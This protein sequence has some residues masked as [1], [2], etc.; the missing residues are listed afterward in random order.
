MT[1]FHATAAQ[2]DPHPSCRK[3]WPTG[4]DY[5]CPRPVADRSG[6]ARFAAGRW[7]PDRSRR[8]RPCS[9]E[10]T[11]LCEMACVRWPAVG[12]FSLLAVGSGSSREEPLCQ[13]AKIGDQW[14]FA[15]TRRRVRKPA[16]VSNPFPPLTRPRAHRLAHTRHRVPRGGRPLFATTPGPNPRPVLGGTTAGG[17]VAFLS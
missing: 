13:A 6:G 3:A 14:R 5:R 17:V 11:G 8:Y 4:V 15:R 1:S 9:S 16:S 7:L 12:S 10:R 2:S